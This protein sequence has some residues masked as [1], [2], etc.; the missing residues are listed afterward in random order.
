MYGPSK[1]RRT[2]PVAVTLVGSLLLASHPAEAASIRFSQI[3]EK[4]TWR[5]AEF[6]E[7][8]ST[9]A[10]VE[11][12]DQ[13]VDALPARLPEAS[14]GV[15]T[16]RP[17]DL[18]RIGAKH[19]RVESASSW[20]HLEG[21]AG[22]WIDVLEFDD[23]SSA[24]RVFARRRQGHSGRTDPNFF[25]FIAYGETP[26][27]T[28]VVGAT[29]RH[30]RYVFNV[31]LEVPFSVRDART[32]D[33]E[34]LQSLDE[35]VT[36]FGLLMEALTRQLVARDALEA[37]PRGPVTEEDRRARRLA[38]FAKLWAEVKY[39]FVFLHERPGLDWDGLLERYMARIAATD[40]QDEYLRI[41]REALAVLRDGHTGLT[42]HGFVDQPPIRIGPIGGRPVVTA[43]GD[44]PE[45]R[46]RGLT[47]GMELVAIDGRPVA[48]VLDQDIY[49][50]VSAS[51]SQ[52]RAVVAFHSILSGQPGTSVEATFL[53][54]EGDERTFELTR[55]LASFG[56]AFE[57][58][59]L[60]EVRDLP[61]GLVYVALNSFADDEVPTLFDEYFGRILDSSGLIIDV[62][63]NGGGSTMN[64]F[65]IVARLIAEPT[66]LTAVERTRVHKPTD[67]ARGLAE[68]WYEYPRDRI[69]PRGEM[70]YL[71]PVAVLIG[72]E[73]FSAAEDFLVPL[74]AMGRATLIG[75]PTAGSTG[76]PLRVPLY[77][78]NARIC[79]KW[80][81]LP[82]GTEFVGVGIRPDI[83][84]E[85]T[86]RDVATGRDPILDRAVAFLS[87][88]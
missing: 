70:P 16:R 31:G 38:S 8:L 64:G 85:P 67:K 54:L 25:V 20:R 87:K 53:D 6:A 2:Q 3:F 50:I 45:L 80:D 78:A 82:D 81:R 15:V 21:I 56:N 84:V 52:G 47:P 35:I 66:T 73:T 60:V 61:G 42:N 49:P 69:E 86:K 88:D 68:E 62:R 33:P 44:T 65:A 40:S 9:S 18:L 10:L 30:D 75:M 12:L 34:K 17:G 37:I 77:G 28:D 48:E 22:L 27:A 26:G 7:A 1:T 63:H 14:L 43:V 4:L 11:N 39:N 58:R 46:A 79:T 71:G 41:L 23:S 13:A 51:T 72:P 55:N 74:A 76:Q 29:V 24:E 32:G 59:S 57:P 36:R 19:V 5:P 83:T